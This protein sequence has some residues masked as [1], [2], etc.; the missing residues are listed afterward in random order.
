MNRPD[1]KDFGVIHMSQQ[2][3]QPNGTYSTARQFRRKLGVTLVELLVGMT[4]LGVILLAA[5]GLLQGNQ[6][7]ASD[8][9]TRSNALGDARGAISRM[10]ETLSQAAYIYPA[11]LTISLN[12]GLVGQG[13]PN[14]ITTG[15]LAIAA[16]VSDGADPPTY[17]GVI[18][19]VAD[20][21]QSKFAAD[22][23]QMPTDRIAQ[24]VLVEAKTIAD[25]AGKQHEWPAKTIP[26]ANWNLNAS[27]GVLVDGVNLN[28][29]TGSDVITNLMV[30]GQF[31]PLTGSDG[32]VF[33]NGLQGAT[34]PPDLYTP[35]A[36]ITTIGYN[37]GIRVAT[38]GKTLAESGTTVLRGLANARNIPRR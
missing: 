13:T 34:T 9:Q 25:A 32:E 37:V 28:G 16:L 11:G 10:T 35:E 22:L 1:P 2:S 24:H 6:R 17:Q 20:R 23:P 27:E 4:I 21:G 18:Y 12:N 5:S 33:K 7:L 36:L 19:Y 38:S 8:T 31:S 29:T 3:T 14:Q 26:T 30:S 15:S